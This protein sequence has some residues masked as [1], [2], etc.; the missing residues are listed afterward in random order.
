MG[1]SSSQELHGQEIMVS[2]QVTYFAFG[3]QEQ[4]YSTISCST[5]IFD[6]RILSSFL[7]LT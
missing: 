4:A 6:F 3:G 5:L 7:K 2:K 1:R